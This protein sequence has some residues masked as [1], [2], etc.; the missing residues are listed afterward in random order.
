MGSCSPTLAGSAVARSGD[1][2]PPLWNQSAAI[3]NTVLN[4]I[5]GSASRRRQ[6]VQL[7]EEQ[8]EGQPDEVGTGPDQQQPEEADAA[9]P[10]GRVGPRIEPGPAGGVPFLQHGAQRGRRR[11]AAQASNRVI[12]SCP[13]MP[14]ARSRSSATRSSTAK[15]TCRLTRRTRRMTA[16]PVGSGACGAPCPAPACGAPWVLCRCGPCCRRRPPCF[17]RSAG[18]AGLLRK[19]ARP[20]RNQPF[21]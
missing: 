15:P 7:Q 4:A 20:R 10:P 16:A 1:A 18:A 13:V 11:R 3:T 2:L 5:A 6:H 12:H 9:Q 14:P 21:G 8:R 17:Q 19:T